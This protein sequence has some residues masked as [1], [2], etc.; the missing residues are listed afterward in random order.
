MGLFLIGTPQAILSQT[1]GALWLLTLESQE[2][3]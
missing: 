3:S 2:Y 1:E